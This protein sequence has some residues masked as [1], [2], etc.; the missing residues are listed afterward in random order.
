[1]LLPYGFADLLD[2]ELTVPF[3]VDVPLEDELDEDP[4]DTDP[5]EPGTDT[6]ETLLPVPLNFSIPVAVDILDDEVLETGLVGVLVLE[7]VLHV[8]SKSGVVATVVPTTP[9]AGW[10]SVSVFASTNVYHCKTSV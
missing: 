10:L 2:P 3:S 6:D 5:V 7:V 1:M 8:I 9:N 4:D